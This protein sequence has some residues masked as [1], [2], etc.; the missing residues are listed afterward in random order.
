[1]A[2]GDGLDLKL[3]LRPG[4]RKGGIWVARI[5]EIASFVNLVRV[6]A[7]TSQRIGALR[8]GGHRGTG[9]LIPPPT[10]YIR[11]MT[12][13]VLFTPQ[14]RPPVEDDPPGEARNSNPETLEDSPAL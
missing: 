4:E 10:V 5:H 14:K 2:V 12:S 1:M 7:G 11:A 8:G 13:Q 3:R 9:S 6:S